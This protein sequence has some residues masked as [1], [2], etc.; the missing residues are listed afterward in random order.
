MEMV[1]SLFSRHFDFRRS[2]ST[3]DDGNRHSAITGIVTFI[4]K[5][6]NVQYSCIIP[7]A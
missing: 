2:H 1:G 5:Q 7:G 6:P 4:L 3:E